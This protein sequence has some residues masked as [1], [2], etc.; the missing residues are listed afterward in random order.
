MGFWFWPCRGR[1]P[2]AD[3]AAPAGNEWRA[4]RA[5]E[6]STAYSALD[7]IN[8][9]N[10]KNLQVAWTWK[11]DNFGGPAS[12]TVAT[13][14]TPLMVNGVLYFTAGA[15]RT[16]VA[17]RA[18]TG[19]TLWTWR[20]DEGARFDQAPRKVH[21]GVAYWTDGQ[22]DERI[23]V[24]TPGFQLISLDAKTGQP[25]A[26]FGRAGAVDLFTQLDNDTKLDPI[27]RIG[28]SSPPVVSNDVIVVGPALTPG[29]R[30]NI[31][32]IKADIMGFDV[33][34][35]RK[36][37]TFHTIPREGEP[38]SET[39]LGD[40]AQYTGNAGVWGPFSADPALGYVYLSVESATN[41][42]YGGHRPGN[43]LF[44]DS[45]VCLDIKTGKM[46]W[47]QQL[48]H[49]DIW[50]YDMPP[51]PILDRPQRGREARARGGAADQAGL[52]VRVRPHQRP[53]GV[54]AGREA[55]PA[56]GGPEGVDGQDAAVPV[57][58]AG[59][60]SAGRD[61]RRSDR[62]HARAARRGSEGH[63]G[64]EARPDLHAHRPVTPTSKG[65]IVVPGFGGGANWPGG[66]ADPETGFVYVGS[67]TNPT[68]A[69][70]T[71][72]T[73]REQS[74]VDTDYTFGGTLPTVQGLRILKPPY[75]RV[76]AYD[77]NKGTIAWQRPN[78][79]TPPAVKNNPALKGLNI[80]PTGSGAQAMLLVTKTLLFSGEGA[81]GQPVFH[82]YDKA[83]GQEIWQT[84]IPGPTTSLPM[85][86]AVNGRQ[87]VVFGVRGTANRRGAQLIAYA[88][89]LPPPAGG[90][91]GAADAA[92]RGLT[93]RS[94]I[95][96]VAKR[97][98]LRAP[99]SR[100]PAVALAVL[101]LVLAA[102]PAWAQHE[103]AFDIEDGSRA[104]RN[105]CQS[106][107]GPDGDEIPGVDLG[108]G[109]FKTASSDADLV[110][111]IRNGVPGTAMP[112]VNMPEEQAVR[113][114]AYL[115]SVAATKRST[116]AAGD[117]VRG[118]ALFE[119]KGQCVTCH[120][121]E[122]RGRPPRARS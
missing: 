75:G 32:N 42:A 97:V 79:D 55:G 99:G 19:E 53:P 114:V 60:R 7:L 110:R 2:G 67:A 101:A 66:A 80:P 45:L 78:G 4:Y 31:A 121:V 33:R 3:S 36:L 70:L 108:R 14:T 63:R 85:T 82:A 54:A 44:S 12:E 43:N 24:V 62:L 115:R 5:E 28:N 65:T 49:H 89:P 40:S 6:G 84:A 56:N 16:V 73:N 64:V 87:F 98:R 93:R 9:D 107:H 1:C 117:A 38:G 35:G 105:S 71:P 122:R 48:V 51:A 106:C 34:T 120:R 27:G 26:A 11:F 21:R 29:G 119:G 17:A 100:L 37:W 23:V 109:Q 118:K 91:P 57:E 18:A 41:D 50:D 86:Y 102:A 112:P 76:T 22:G 103:T 74:R 25:K 69:G 72:N 30:V 15:R 96:G 95:V 77:M 116:S 59:V 13:E 92:A 39:W 58:A 47:Y 113:I 81:G 83:T 90:A 8:R 10:V 94:R 20:P 88:L 46:I 52:R 61:A 104:F 111:I 68:G